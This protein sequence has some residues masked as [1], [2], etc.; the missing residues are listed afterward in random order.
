MK[1]IEDGFLGWTLV[2]IR[3][4]THTHKY[5]SFCSELGACASHDELFVPQF[6]HFLKFSTHLAFHL[7]SVW[8]LWT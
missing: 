7:L 3:Q 1:E 5:F 6:V 4:F 8:S 2:E